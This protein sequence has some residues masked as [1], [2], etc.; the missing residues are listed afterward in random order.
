MKMRSKMPLAA[1]FLSNLMARHPAP[2]PGRGRM[3]LTELKHGANMAS[4]T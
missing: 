3:Q 1:D 4:G 2:H